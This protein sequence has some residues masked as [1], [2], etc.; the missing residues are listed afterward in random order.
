VNHHTTADFWDCHRQLPPEVQHVADANYE[1]LRA[2]S[3]HPSL[4][5]KRVGRL[6]SVR[7]GSGYRA[8]A[9]DSDDGLI[10]FWIGPHTEYERIIGR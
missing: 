9:A 4:H 2:N 7:V 6:W 8:L 3:R 1:L 5:F 10:W